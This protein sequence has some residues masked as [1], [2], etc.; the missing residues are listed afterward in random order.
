[1]L[2]IMINKIVFSIR[3]MLRR[4]ERQKVFQIQT[5]KSTRKNKVSSLRLIKSFHRSTIR[6]N[7][8]LSRGD[9][10][11]LNYGLFLWSKGDESAP[12]S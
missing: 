2:Y 8:E 4:R 10:C 7:L 12:I 9:A 1:M 5:Q 11:T 3:D 6:I